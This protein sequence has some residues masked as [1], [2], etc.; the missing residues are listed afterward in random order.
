MFYCRAFPPQRYV[1]CRLQQVDYS[2]N[3]VDNSLECTFFPQTIIFVIAVSA[4][5]WLTIHWRGPYDGLIE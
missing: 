1:I 3:K 2:A 5:R 4:V